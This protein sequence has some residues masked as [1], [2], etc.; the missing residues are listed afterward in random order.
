LRAE[1]LD[2]S[3]TVDALAFSPDGARIVTA[4]GHGAAQVHGAGTGKVLHELS[5]HVG[6]VT[7]A[8]FPP[9]GTL[10]VT[11][12]QEGTV[13]L[14]D[15]A[16]GE[17]TGTVE[18][19]SPSETQMNSDPADPVGRLL[20]RR[21]AHRS[22]GHRRHGQG[23]GHRH[24]RI[25][26]V[27]SGRTGAMNDLDC[28]ADGRRTATAGGNTA[29]VWDASTGTLLAARSSTEDSAL[30]V[31]FSPD[32]T[33]IATAED[34]AG[35]RVWD[36]AT[37]R[38]LVTFTGRTDAVSDVAFSPDGTPLLTASSD[39]TAQV[40]SLPPSWP[41]ELCR[42]A[43]RDLTRAERNEY[44]GNL[45]YEPRC[46]QWPSRDPEPLVVPVTRLP[47]PQ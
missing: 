28:S 26:L 29:R 31:A 44:L 14:R 41:A 8:G 11:G 35:V 37:G 25:A 23:P 22:G 4:G 20:P 40:R 24:G 15:A 12:G 36:A 33:R 43:G 2:P 21:P 1:V 13:R 18:G 27:L 39:T 16:T 19:R 5:G 9:G 32:G 34:D 45:P 38:L 30:T 3:D 42:G 17:R 6:R 7:R 47:D 46:S 10:L